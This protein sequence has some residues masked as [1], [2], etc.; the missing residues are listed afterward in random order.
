MPGLT[1]VYVGPAD[2]AISMGHRPAEGLATP[3]VL[4]AITRIQSVA[5]QAGIV[6]GI[7]A[8]RG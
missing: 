6:P 3:A 2:L 4:D 5:S 8:E 7:H 1:G